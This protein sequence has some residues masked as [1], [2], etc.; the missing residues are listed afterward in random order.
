MHF[1][2][3]A[4][5]LNVLSTIFSFMLS[6]EYYLMKPTYLKLPY[7]MFS[8]PRCHRNFLGSKYLSGQNVHKCFQNFLIFS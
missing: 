3:P 4:C 1:L 5:E 7:D 6:E 8:P 2:P